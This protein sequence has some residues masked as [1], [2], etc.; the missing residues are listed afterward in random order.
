MVGTFG[1]NIGHFGFS[2][3]VNVYASYVYFDNCHAGS[4]GCWSWRTVEMITFG[5]VGVL[6][7]FAHIPLISPSNATC[8]NSDECFQRNLMHVLLGCVFICFTLWNM[9]MQWQ[10]RNIG[11]N[12]DCFGNIRGTATVEALGLHRKEIGT[13]FTVPLMLIIAG[14]IMTTH[15]SPMAA[16]DVMDQYEMAQNVLHVACGWLMIA[17]GFCRWRLDYDS[18]FVMIY[19]VVVSIFSTVWSGSSPEFFS[20]LVDSRFSGHAIAV[21]L[22]VVGTVY[23]L[24]QSIVLRNIPCSCPAAYSCCCRRSTRH[25][26]IYSAE[27]QQSHPS[28]S[29]SISPSIP[30]TTNQV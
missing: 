14:S 6:A 29:P 18:S 21:V 1:Q 25:E 30:L 7:L 19:Y 28:I 12:K 16:M 15:G 8:Y 5:V 17:A 3:L 20:P 9:N 24:V 13:D 26:P 4:M 22:I 23:A 27:L 2:I 10:R 11:E